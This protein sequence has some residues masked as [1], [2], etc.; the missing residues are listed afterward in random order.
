MDER[1]RVAATVALGQIGADAASVVPRLLEELD[2]PGAK[3][4]AAADS[5][6]KFGEAS[7]PALARALAGA[8]HPDATVHRVMDV[9]RRLGAAATAPSRRWRSS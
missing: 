5:L 3:T 6:V 2:D 9:L 7:V 4:R 1:V 8:D